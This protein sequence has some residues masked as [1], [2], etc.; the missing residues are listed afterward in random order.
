MKLSQMI[1]SKY[2]CVLVGAYQ[3]PAGDASSNRLLSLAKT[4]QA[5]GY[6]PL[7]LNDAR[8]S[9]LDNSRGECVATYEGID[10]LCIAPRRNDRISRLLHRLSRPVRSRRIIGRA[11][12]G[13]AAPPWVSIASGLYTLGMH[14]AIRF[15]TGT[16]LLADVVERHDARQF[17]RGRLDPYFIR[18]RFT[19]FICGVLATKVIVISSTLEKRY[20]RRKSTLVLPP[21][22]DVTKFG[23][24]QTDSGPD[25]KLRILYMGRPYS[26]DIFG[27]MLRGLL[28]IGPEAADLMSVIV[29]GVGRRELIECEDVGIE[30]YKSMAGILDVIGLVS[31]S[32]IL[33]ILQD[34]DFTFLLRPN[35]GYARSG[36][37]SKV[38]ESLAA[39]CPVITNFTS[40]L[41]AYLTD[42]SDSLISTSVGIDDVSTVLRRALSLSPVELQRM[43]ENAR[44]TAAQ[45]LDYRNW[46]QSLAL[47]LQK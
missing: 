43:S 25:R 8:G 27:P 38:P 47:F 9:T 30:L 2:S 24:H 21:A 6:E 15:F 26:K 14:V 39:G 36:F 31:H 45:K 17:S 23:V 40:D 22:I 13:A 44:A 32:R 28:E 16:T 18:H 34:V 11:T 37:P 4:F 3:F 35:A 29:A 19:S 20:A 33:E 10:Y 1:E 7:I 46:A 12:H 42:G 41:G 5:A